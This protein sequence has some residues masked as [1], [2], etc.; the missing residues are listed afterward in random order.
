MEVN[1]RHPGRIIKIIL[2]SGSARR[3]LLGGCFNEMVWL[4]IALGGRCGCHGAGVFLCAVNDG[5]GGAAA[6]GVHATYYHFPPFFSRHVA[7]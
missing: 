3:W 5:D 6:G 7:P 1:W 4:T 2:R